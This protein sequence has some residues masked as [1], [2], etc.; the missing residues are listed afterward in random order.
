[1]RNSLYINEC[2]TFK[3]FRKQLDKRYL[4]PSKEL[5]YPELQYQSI[6]VSRNYYSASNYFYAFPPFFNYNGL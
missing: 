2:N 1:M 5:C 4:I 6:I 3:T